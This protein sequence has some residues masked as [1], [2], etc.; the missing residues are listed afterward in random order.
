MTRF[1]I[2][3]VH[4]TMEM[5]QWNL[6]YEMWTAFFWLT[7]LCLAELTWG[8][9][10]TLV[11]TQMTSGYWGIESLPLVVGRQSFKRLV[12]WKITMLCQPCRYLSCLYV[13]IRLLASDRLSFYCKQGKSG[14][15]WSH[16][17]MWAVYIRGVNVITCLWYIYVP[18]LKLRGGSPELAW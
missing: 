14:N 9:M 5:W 13:E 12:A 15:T 7:A 10:D 2:R 16:S 6:N 8:D 18:C 11:K 17:N 1:R 4:Q 3:V